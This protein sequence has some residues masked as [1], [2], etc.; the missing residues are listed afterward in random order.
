MAWESVAEGTYRLQVPGG[1]LYRY[2][3]SD[4]GGVAM[5]FVP[6]PGV[7]GAAGQV[8]IGRIPGPDHSDWGRV[9]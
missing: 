9:G 8:E 7:T 2:R 1:W 3:W 4:S 5:C 6:S